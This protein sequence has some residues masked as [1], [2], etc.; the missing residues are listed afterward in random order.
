MK[1]APMSAPVSE[2][3]YA[4]PA[5]HEVGAECCDEPSRPYS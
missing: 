4:A 1:I 5:S 3:F 2:I